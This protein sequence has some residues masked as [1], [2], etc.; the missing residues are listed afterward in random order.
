MQDFP[1]FTTENGAAG[2]VLREI[3]YRGEAFITIHDTLQPR[4]L[5]QDC[6]EFCRIAGAKKVYA[7]GHKSLENYPLHTIILKMQQMRQSLGNTDA[8]LFPV[9]EKTAELWQSLYNKKMQTVPNASTMTRKD[10]Q[11]LLMKGTGYFVHRDKDLLGI[12]IAG[13]DTVEAVIANQPRMGETVM[14]ALCG[15]LSSETV[16]LEVAST[17]APAMRLYERLGFQMTA[18]ISRWYDVGE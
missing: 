5:L 4:E 10:M 18:E 3:P 17:N 15:A 12:G 14:L 13:G 2:L 16:V 1:V 7:T 11:N 6:I 9:T 8:A